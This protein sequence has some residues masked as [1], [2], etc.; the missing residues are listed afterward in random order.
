MHDLF[1]KIIKKHKLLK[2]IALNNKRKQLIS[3]N[4]EIDNSCNY[5]KKNLIIA[6]M[7][8]KNDKNL[9]FILLILCESK[10]INIVVILLIALRKNF[11]K[12]L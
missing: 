2:K 9:L 6:I 8:I 12:T 1:N 7:K 3:K 5:K 4:L 10:K 11:K